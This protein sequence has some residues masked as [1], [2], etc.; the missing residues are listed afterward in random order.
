MDSRGTNTTEFEIE[1]RY[2]EDIWSKH[3]QEVSTH[4]ESIKLEILK[5]NKEHL[6]SYKG[7]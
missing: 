7:M 5:E 1:C 3:I 4:F 6:D 2:L